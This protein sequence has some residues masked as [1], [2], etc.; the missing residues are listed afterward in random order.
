MRIS[1]NIVALGGSFGDY[2]VDSWFRSQNRSL[3]SFFNRFIDL[4]SAHGLLIDEIN[5]F[6]GN[7][8][9]C[10]LNELNRQYLEVGELI[11]LKN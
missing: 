4:F 7:L 2:I 10:Q 1:S 11:L 9:K 6:I 8:M 5:W 3:A